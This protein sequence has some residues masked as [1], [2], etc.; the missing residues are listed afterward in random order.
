MRLP[1]ELFL[2]IFRFIKS[3]AH[4]S[5]ISLS[6][7]L[8]SYYFMIKNYVMQMKPFDKEF[9]ID[10]V[11][12]QQ[13]FNLFEK[14]IELDPYFK[15]KDKLRN[16]FNSCIFN[17]FTN[18]LKF[19][20]LKKIKPN[21]NSSKYFNNNINKDTFYLLIKKCNLQINISII[22]QLI[23]NDCN[24]ILLFLYLNYP[25]KFKISYSNV[26]KVAKKENKFLLFFFLMLFDQNYNKKKECFIK[27]KRQVYEPRYVS[28][29]IDKYFKLFIN[30]NDDGDLLDEKNINTSQNYLINTFLSCFQDTLLD[31]V[32]KYDDLN[33]LKLIFEKKK[34]FT[35]EEIQ[36]IFNYSIRYS[37]FFCLQF[38]LDLNIL[39]IPIKFLIDD[40]IKTKIKKLLYDYC[41]KSESLDVYNSL[42]LLQE[43]ILCENKKLIIH[44]T[45][46]ILVNENKFYFFN[47]KRKNNCYKLL[48]SFLIKEIE[49]YLRE[50]SYTLL[51]KEN[52][53]VTSLL[54]FFN[55]ILEFYT[56]KI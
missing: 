32:I 1:L 48:K 39:R 11:I 9:F 18:G 27:S 45:K 16:L 8:G 30:V 47:E 19:L 53:L 20:A 34:Y 26:E 17:N 25:T 2:E 6:I 54:T 42:T 21:Y 7:A 49:E 41:M 37:S 56:Q 33:M 5:A 44:F 51:K 4:E 46:Y 14:M 13:H 40:D 29:V 3:N 38:V 24:D 15:D 52:E 31:N 23:E 10:Y 43:S 36:N 55:R 28:L 12:K 50:F 22:N 35:K